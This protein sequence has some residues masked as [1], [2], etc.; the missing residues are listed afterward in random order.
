MKIQE[1]KD[2]VGNERNLTARY[3]TINQME[4]GVSEGKLFADDIPVSEKVAEELYRTLSISPSY[5]KKFPVELMLPHVQYKA[6][7]MPNSVTMLSNQNELMAISRRSFNPFYNSEIG[8]A[9]E[10]SLG[11]EI[12]IDKLQYSIADTQFWITNGIRTEPRPGDITKAGIQIK[13]SLIGNYKP[14]IALVAERLVCS[15][16]MT[17]ADTIMSLQFNQY[18]GLPTLLTD[19]WARA[20]RFVDNIAQTSTVNINPN[21]GVLA[22]FFHKHGVGGRTIAK[23]LAAVAEQH[24][25]TLYDLINIL[26]YI[27]THDSKGY[28]GKYKLQTL[29]AQL[30]EEFDTC[31]ECHNILS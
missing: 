23:I 4:F 9:I 16:G 21:P 20:Q 27:G 6:S 24:P 22:V 7:G 10:D 31:G 17:R 8:Q 15:N 12:N 28:W 13:N 26:T 19:L 2:K 30:T 3:T 11:D 1:F 29:G 5:A 18:S 25:T 14:E